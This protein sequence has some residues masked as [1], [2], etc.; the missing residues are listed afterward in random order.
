MIESILDFGPGIMRESQQSHLD[1][2]KDLTPK[3]HLVERVTSAMGCIVAC[4][5][6]VW[7]PLDIDQIT[8]ELSTRHE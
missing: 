2:L 6:I 5:L 4:T 1:L 7:V 3:H 8:K